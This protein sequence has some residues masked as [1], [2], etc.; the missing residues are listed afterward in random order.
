MFSYV[1]RAFIHCNQKQGELIFE[2]YDAAV[3]VFTEL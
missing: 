3:I 1:F 2:S